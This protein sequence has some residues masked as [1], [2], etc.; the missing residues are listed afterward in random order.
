MVKRVVC[1]H[2]CCSYQIQ[3]CTYCFLVASWKLAFSSPTGVFLQVWSC[4]PVDLAGGGEIV[5][6]IEGEIVEA[7]ESEIMEVIDGEIM[8]VIEGDGGD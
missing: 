7:I 8:D 4:R 3:E 1:S 5:V 2:L 6:V